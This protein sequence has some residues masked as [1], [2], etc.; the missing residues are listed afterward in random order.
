MSKAYDRVECQF[1]KEFMFRLGFPEN[2]VKKIMVCVGTV[3]YKIK[4]NG[5]CLGN[6]SERIKAR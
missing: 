3:C 6:Y 5:K 2:W 1:L 4:I